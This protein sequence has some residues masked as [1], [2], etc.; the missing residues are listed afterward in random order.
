MSDA[1]ERFEQGLDAVAAEAERK[2]VHPVE[3]DAARCTFLGAAK[4]I[5]LP[6]PMGFA[7]EVGTVVGSNAPYILCA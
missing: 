1:C 3:I 4:P 6:D 2:V 5:E 7:L